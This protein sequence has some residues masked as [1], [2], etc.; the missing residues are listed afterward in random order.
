ML[1]QWDGPGQTFDRTPLEAD[2]QLLV[3]EPGGLLHGGRAWWREGPAVHTYRAA[4]TARHIPGSAQADVDLTAGVL[5]GAAAAAT[6]HGFVLL[7]RASNGLYAPSPNAAASNV[8][9]N[10][11]WTF[12][13]QAADGTDRLYL[14]GLCLGLIVSRP[15]RCVPAMWRGGGVGRHFFFWSATFGCDKKENGTQQGVRLNADCLH[16][17][18]GKRENPKPPDEGSK[19]GENAETEGL[20]GRDAKDGALN[21]ALLDRVHDACGAS[22]P[23]N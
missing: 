22:T 4:A 2:H 12:P 17:P 3:T 15:P 7:V 18:A 8:Y 19:E 5:D 21:E 23:Q 11:A 10:P 14:A 1:C 13:V 16:P 20:V 6:R 9:T